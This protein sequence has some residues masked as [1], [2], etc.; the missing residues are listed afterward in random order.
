MLL[1]TF[2]CL[3]A[4]PQAYDSLVVEN[5]QWKVMYDDDF[6]PWEDA[7]NGW[8]LRGDTLI[9]GL[10]YKKLYSRSFEEPNSD[11]II[12]QD[13]FG[14]LREDIENKKVYAI[15][16]LSGW[17]GC[18]TLNDEYLLFDFSMTIGDTSQMCI[19]TE[20]IGDPVLTEIYLENVFGKDRNIYDY[21]MESSKFIEGVGHFQGLMES[22]VMLVSRLVFTQLIDYCHGTDEECGVLYVKVGENSFKDSFSIYPNP[23][24]DQVRIHFYNEIQNGYIRKLLVNDIYGRCVFR[25]EDPGQDINVDVSDLSEGM[26]FL[27]FYKGDKIVSSKKLFI[28][29]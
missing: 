13:L 4:M 29:R 17:I 19:L 20:N 24:S 6:T 3:R 27:N 2:L 1:L 11:V 14:C 9:N 23:A 8:L 28:A 22:P 26:Y 16:F 21:G 18:D 15:D 5:A 10:Q 25:K 12:S 7:L